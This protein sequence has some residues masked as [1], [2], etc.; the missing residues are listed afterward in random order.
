MKRILFPI[1]VI[2][3][4]SILLILFNRSNRAEVFTVEEKPIK[5]VIY[6]SGYV[7]PRNYVVIRSEVSGYV[8]EIRVKEGDRVRK[9][10]ILA[11][12]DA[13]P[14]E[15]SLREAQERLR[16]SKERLREDSDYRRSLEKQVEITKRNM[17]QAQRYLFRRESL[18]QRGLIPREQ[19]EEAKRSYEN[20]KSE[21]EK[22]LTTYR[23]S[24]K[25]L[26][27][28]ERFLSA[29]VERIKK[30]LDKYYIKSPINGVVL[31]KYVEV[32]EYI[33]HI[34]QDN[35]LFSVGESD[36]KE[37]VLNVDEEYASSIKSGM[38]VYLSLDV[39]PNRVFEGKLV[40]I[41]GEINKNKKTLEVKAVADL[42]PEVPANATVEAN[43]LVEDRKALVIPKS[44]YKNGF[45]YKYEKVRRVKVPVKVGEEFN[46]YLEVLEGLKKG[47]KV[48]VE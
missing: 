1:G 42:P 25:A 46:G 37:I 36:A 44:A 23:D 9:G 7:K 14:V 38:K 43:I 13:G 3:T 28:E 2:L 35:K 21:Y 29:S 24:I 5:K 33:N 22:A 26:E 40:Q 15:E 4:V 31:N 16:L 10:E 20:A 11:V 18:A 41:E 39:Y 19:Y 8:K 30:E 34:S 27:S 32:G 17:E 48:V 12:M 47:D 6:A 45:V